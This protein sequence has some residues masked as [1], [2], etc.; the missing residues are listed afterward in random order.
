MLG[1]RSYAFPST[2]YQGYTMS[3][4]HITDDVNLTPWRKW[5]LLGFWEVDISPF[6]ITKY[7][8]EHFETNI[9]CLLKLRSTNLCIH[10]RIADF[11]FTGG[12][13]MPP[14]IFEKFL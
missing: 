10:D 3:T 5:C 4:C 12:R 2:S 11:P 8:V 7:F 14:L 1:M 6:L 13:K 9:L